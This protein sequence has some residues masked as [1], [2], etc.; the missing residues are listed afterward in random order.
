MTDG[1]HIATSVHTGFFLAYVSTLNEA[2][3]SSETSVDSQQ[4]TRVL[5][6]K[7]DFIIPSL[8]TSNPTCCEQTN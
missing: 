8:R 2:I 7:V 4:T 5:S 3:F 1:G 6:H